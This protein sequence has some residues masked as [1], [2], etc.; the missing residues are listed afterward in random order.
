MRHLLLILV[1]FICFVTGCT[2]PE[3]RSTDRQ[4]RNLVDD[5]IQAYGGEPA[6]QKITGY[7]AYGKL[8]A[9][10]RN[11]LIRTTRWFQRPDRLLLELNYPDQ[12]EWRLTLADKSWT[13][14]SVADLQ[15][16]IGPVTW[17]MRLQTARFD[18][19]LRLLER[20]MELQM[21][22]PDAGGCSVLR[23]NLG[24]GLS[25][26]YHI[27]PESHYIVRMTMGMIGPPAMIFAADYSGFEEV[28]GV[29]FPH[30]ETTW[31]GETMT[32]RVVI[33]RFN[34]N[35]PG[36]AESLIGPDETLKITSLTPAK[37]F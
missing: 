37:W 26:D 14:P 13:G 8:H 23:L 36:L 4:I 16:A 28:N 24:D 21:R 6:L 3:N 18:L 7:V 30:R 32:S 27:D 33:E 31:A 12:P 1:M 29:I 17:S 25:I 10:H 11:A 2:S 22:E 9:P 35:P 20:E 19:P 34:I 5:V 15:P